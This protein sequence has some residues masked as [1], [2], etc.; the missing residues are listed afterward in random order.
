MCLFI[1][2]EL[3]LAE[4]LEFV[5]LIKLFINGVVIFTKLLKQ[6]GK[7]KANGVEI[8]IFP[9]EHILTSKGEKDGGITTSDPLARF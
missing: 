1:F 6:G 7:F 4:E 9:V 2:S 5:L 3:S 8:E